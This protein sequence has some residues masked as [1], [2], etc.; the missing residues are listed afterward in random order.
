MQRLFPMTAIALVLAAGS[1]TSADARQARSFVHAADC[2]VR[3]M[4]SDVQDARGTCAAPV[5]ERKRVRTGRSVQAQSTHVARR[6]SGASCGGSLIAVRAQSGA[7]A[8]VASYASSKFQSFVTALEATGYRID[9]MG[10]WR[11][12]GSCR[13]CNMHPRGLAIDINQ[14]ARNRV[15]RRFPAGVTSLA[16]QNGLLHGA[17]WQHA[18]AGHFELLTASNAHYAQRPN[19]YASAERAM[20]RYVRRR[21]STLGTPVTALYT[22]SAFD[23][24]GNRYR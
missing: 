2:S 13:G 8:C 14:T 12:H 9:F 10:G 16:E 21:T 6:A 17:V 7:V 1:T 15:T 24:H 20:H 18:D 22:E 11:R 23:V 19:T 4:G 5:A 3:V